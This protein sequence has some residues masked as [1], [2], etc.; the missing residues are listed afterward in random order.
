MKSM[1]I[2]LVGAMTA[3]TLLGGCANS[4]NPA[5]SNNTS[6][7]PSTSSSSSSNF[8]G[9]GV[10]EDIETIKVSEDGKNIAGTLIGGT[11]GGLLGHQVGSGK[12]QTAATVAGVVGGAVA[13][14]EIEKRSQVA[15]REEYRIRVRLSNGT[16]HAVTQ[17]SIS[18]IKI[19]DRVRV[20]NDRVSRAD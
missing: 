18:D 1:Q 12:G 3:A 4:S 6:S 5:A 8:I 14:H 9:Y 16:T 13:G 2:I 7:L 19:G 15:S 20:D 10:V 17:S 11:V